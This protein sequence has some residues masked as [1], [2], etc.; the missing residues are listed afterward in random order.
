MTL[1]INIEDKLL[2]FVIS[3]DGKDFDWVELDKLDQVKIISVIC[4]AYEFF[5]KRCKQYFWYCHLFLVYLPKL[6][7]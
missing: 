4:S 6:K 2:S 7:R 1:K 3:K 5:S